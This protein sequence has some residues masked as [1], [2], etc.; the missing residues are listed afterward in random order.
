MMNKLS[1]EYDGIVLYM[2]LCEK[3]AI[4]L[5]Y[6]T[7][8][9]QAILEEIKFLW[10]E[11]RRLDEL[12]PFEEIIE[13]IK[14]ESNN[15]SMPFWYKMISNGI[16][17]PEEKYNEVFRYYFDREDYEKCEKMKNAKKEFDEKTS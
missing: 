16:I 17:P 2:E 9:F 13:K 10:S 15:H 11:S 12:E 5:N 7:Y 3:L 8:D 6:P 14:N 1:N 4:A